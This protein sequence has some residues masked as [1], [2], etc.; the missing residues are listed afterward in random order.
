MGGRARSTS[1]CSSAAA[2]VCKRQR[3][4]RQRWQRR[5]RSRGR[6]CPRR[7]RSSGSFCGSTR[8]AAPPRQTCYCILP[9]TAAHAGHRHRR[10][11]GHARPTPCCR[12]PASYTPLRAHETKAKPVC[13]LLLE[14]KKPI[15]LTQTSIS[16]L[17]LPAAF[18]Y[19][20]L[21]INEKQQKKLI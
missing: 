10:R 7:W 12:I 1:V 13:R 15:T 14:K 21:L 8:W 6:I 17:L 4:H 18:T 19:T 3:R 20:I 5:R 16:A 2:D 9:A 11:R